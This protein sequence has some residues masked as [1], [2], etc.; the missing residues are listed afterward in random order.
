MTQNRWGLETKKSGLRNLWLER[1]HYS[2]KPTG[3][4]KINV[5]FPEIIITR[6]KII[7]DVVI[8]IN[9]MSDVC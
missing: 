7:V 1:L 3:F 6:T 8:V 4:H 2:V 9:M 5:T